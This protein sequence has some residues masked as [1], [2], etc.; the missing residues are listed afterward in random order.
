M[1]DCTCLE[2]PRNFRSVNVKKTKNN[3]YARLHMPRATPSFPFFFNWPT[4]GKTTAAEMIRH[5]K[6]KANEVLQNKCTGIEGK[7]TVLA[8]KVV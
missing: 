3:N 7:Q 4:I 6:R 1:H 5:L 8:N 2:Q